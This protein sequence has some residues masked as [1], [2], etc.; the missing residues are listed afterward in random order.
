MAKSKGAWG[1]CRQAML[2]IRCGG[3]DSE[4]IVMMFM[5]MMS[6]LCLIR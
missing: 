3:G 1:L 2:H 4:I 6:Q 5:M